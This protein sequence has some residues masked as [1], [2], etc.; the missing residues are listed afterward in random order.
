MKN[1]SIGQISLLDLFRS[2]R[3]L[4][5]RPQTKFPFQYQYI[6]L[7]FF[8]LSQSQVLSFV[9]IAL[10]FNS[11]VV[12]HLIRFLN[13]SEILQFRHGKLISY[14]KVLPHSPTVNHS[15]NFTKDFQ[16]FFATVSSSVQT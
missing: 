4:K 10:F 8:L 16:H 1:P 6:R 14:N 9:N 7:N 15:K 2:F 12:F 13:F 3:E 11:K 5:Y